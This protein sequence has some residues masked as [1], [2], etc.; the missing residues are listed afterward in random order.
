MI[1]II[2][3]IGIVIAALCLLFAIIDNVYHNVYEAKSKK[4]KY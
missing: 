3:T 1:N 4:K 2:V